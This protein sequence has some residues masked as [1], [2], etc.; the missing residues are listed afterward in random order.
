VSALVAATRLREELEELCQVLVS[1]DGTTL[2]A[3][4]ERLALAFDA[5]A[6]A[7]RIDS[8]E[9]AAL[10]ATLRGA[11]A[12]LIRCQTLGAGIA[13]VAHSMLV[14]RGQEP[15]YDHAGLAA[16]YGSGARGVSVDA[17]L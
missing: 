10:A 2:V 5:L 6:K 3:M 7:D 9:R 8:S 1:G 14:A 12:A 15:T 4:E 17:R 13:L 11:R 16:A